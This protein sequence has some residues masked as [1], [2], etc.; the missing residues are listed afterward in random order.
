MKLLTMSVDFKFV[1]IFNQYSDGV[2]LKS[3]LLRFTQ[4]QIYK[5]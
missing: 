4:K 3:V 1:D 5:A 2:Y